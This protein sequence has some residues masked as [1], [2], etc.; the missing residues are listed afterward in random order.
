MCTAGDLGR[1][2]L[3]VMELYM[4]CTVHFS[5]GMDEN[6]KCVVLQCTIILFCVFL[7]RLKYIM[8]INMYVLTV[9]DLPFHLIPKSICSNFVLRNYEEMKQKINLSFFSGISTTN[10]HIFQNHIKMEITW[11]IKFWISSFQS[12]SLF[13]QKNICTWL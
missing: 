3:E 6:G 1:V 12:C 9:H 5:I 4:H 10:F 8:K 11:I 2:N 13:Y 7:T